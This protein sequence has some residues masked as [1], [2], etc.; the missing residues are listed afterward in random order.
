MARRL[1]VTAGAILL[2]LSVA[3][4][5]I[6]GAP[7][8]VL[9]TIGAITPGKLALGLLLLLPMQFCNST[10]LAFGV[11]V[12]HSY[13]EWQRSHEIVP[14]QMAGTTNLW[15]TVPA[16][17]AGL[18]ALIFTAAN[19]LYL[20]PVSFRAFE[21]LR[22]GITNA[23]IPSA[24]DTGYLQKVGPD[25]SISFRRRLDD[26]SVE[27]V[28]VLDGRSSESFT[29]IVAD[30]GRFVYEPGK[31]PEYHFVLEHGY[32]YRLNPNES[33]GS[34]AT[35]E[36][37][38]VPITRG[39]PKQRWRGWYE[40]DIVTLFNPPALVRAVPVEYGFWIAE[41][42]NRLVV[43]FAP[44][45]YA[46][47]VAGVMLRPKPARTGAGLYAALC[48]CAVVAWHA[49]FTLLQSLIAT[50]P[51]LAPVDAVAALIP[52]ALGFTL[53]MLPPKPSR[54]VGPQMAFW[55]PMPA[56]ARPDST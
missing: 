52:A 14:L 19:S 23:I 8:F 25:L 49:L 56:P 31:D 43:P 36:E 55:R 34:P 33:H 12:T 1:L 9:L 4:A 29:Y 21:D 28:T 37:L 51:V 3:G 16:I 50:I 17:V 48:L 46:L 42:T 27:G 2:T 24:L 32:Y 26:Q 22:Y 39:A 47:L 15:L 54:R 45:S 10:P 30:R 40:E 13:Y 44:L 5:L 41:G 53:V 7:L 18:V 35:F 11:A 6:E 20:L 38:V